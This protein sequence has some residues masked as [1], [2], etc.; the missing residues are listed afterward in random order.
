MATDRRQPRRPAKSQDQTVLGTTAAQEINEPNPDW[1]PI[2]NA[3]CHCFKEGFFTSGK[4]YFDTLHAE[5][6]RILNGS[7]LGR[8]PDYSVRQED[9]GIMVTSMGVSTYIALHAI[10]I[11][12]EGDYGFQH[13]LVGG[14]PCQIFEGGLKWEEW[15]DISERHRLAAQWHVEEL[16]KPIL[17]SW[18]YYLQEA[19]KS[20]AVQ[21]MA[22][23]DS[24]QAPFERVS[25]DQW[26]YFSLSE[27]IVERFNEPTGVARERW[28]DPLKPSWIVDTPTTS[29]ATGPAGERLF[30]IYVARGPSSAMRRSTLQAMPSLADPIDEGLSRAG[31]NGPD[32]THRESP[33]A[34]PGANEKKL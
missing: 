1:V 13:W 32:R 23:K 16:V 14:H 27:P 22:R 31:A 11:H 28:A 3:P 10:Y 33:F 18:N 17:S 21:I 19:I 5:V 9:K 12:P 24:V 29:V 20:G 8:H 7:Q 30:A 6:N 2:W 4:Q 25:Y 15:H 26:Q 34:F